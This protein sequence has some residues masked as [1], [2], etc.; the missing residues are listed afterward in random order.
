MTEVCL[1]SSRVT[2]LRTLAWSGHPALWV[3]RA[4]GRRSSMMTTSPSAPSSQRIS[5]LSRSSWLIRNQAVTSSRSASQRTDQTLS[6][7]YITSH[8]I[9]PLPFEE[10]K[11]GRITGWRLKHPRGWNCS[12]TT[13]LC[14]LYIPTGP[15]NNIATHSFLSLLWLQS[16][17]SQL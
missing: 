14:V 15:F 13:H 3:Q 10:V 5:T 11:H 7:C 4:E 12:F 9:A 8:H 1:C 2:A 16:V 6:R 17:R